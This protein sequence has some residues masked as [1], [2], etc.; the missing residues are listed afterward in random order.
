MISKTIGFRG[1]L[2]SDKP[3]LNMILNMGNAGQSHSK[4]GNLHRFYS[5]SSLWRHTMF[6]CQNSGHCTCLRHAVG[7][8]GDSANVGPWDMTWQLEWHTNARE[9]E[10]F[11][12]LSHCIVLYTVYTQMFHQAVN[13]NGSSEECPRVSAKLF[14]APFLA[15]PS[16]L[17]QLPRGLRSPRRV[18][19]HRLKTASQIKHARNELLSCPF[20]HRNIW[21]PL[22]S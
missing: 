16:I 20:A 18:V 22:V 3:I 14:A 9:T 7:W 15:R 8:F 10:I 13:F 11:L 6:W 17:A 2:F 19:G 4:Q 12:T 21:I 5:L 1:T